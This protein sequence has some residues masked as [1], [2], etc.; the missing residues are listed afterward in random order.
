MGEVKLRNKGE[1]KILFLEMWIRDPLE[2]SNIFFLA[3]LGDQ[4]SSQHTA[5]PDGCTPLINR[6]RHHLASQCF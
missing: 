4:L 3:S 5:Y 2:G 6:V 1:H